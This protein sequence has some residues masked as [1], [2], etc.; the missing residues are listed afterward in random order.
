[1][2]Y[3]YVE[4]NR[5]LEFKRNYI[6]PIFVDGLPWKKRLL[7]EVIH[8]SDL[9]D[10]IEKILI[11]DKVNADNIEKKFNYLRTKSN[12]C[13]AMLDTNLSIDASFD[14]LSKAM[15]YDGILESLD[16][17]SYFTEKIIEDIKDKYGDDFWKVIQSVDRA[18]LSE[19]M[20]RIQNNEVIK[21]Y[22]EDDE[23]IKIYLVLKNWQD[24][25]HLFYSGKLENIRKKIEAEYLEKYKE[26]N[27]TNTSNPQILREL[28][29]LEL[30]G[31]AEIDYLAECYLAGMEKEIGQLFGGKALGLAKL[32]ANNVLIPDTVALSY[33]SD[34]YVLNF[35]SDKYA[36]RSSA[37]I[38]D[39][40]KYSFAGMFDTYLDIRKED[41]PEAIKKV[42]LSV[43][44]KRVKEYIRLNKLRYPRMSVVIQKF[45]EPELAGV[46][47]G[48]TITSGY[49]EYV[50]GNGEKLVSGRENPM[51]ENWFK[52]GELSYIK[53]KDNKYIGEELIRLQ[54]KLGTIAD[55]E[56]C[57]VDGKL[58][59]LQYRAV[60]SE[61]A[62]TEK[63]SG[64]DDGKIYGIAAS[65]GYVEA[66]ATYIRKIDE[67]N[68]EE[69]KDG[70]ILMAW[71][72][73]PEW[74]SVLEHCSGIV[75]AVG[76]FLCHSAIIA[77]ELGIP[78]VIGI[79]N[80]MKTIWNEKKLIVDGSNGF[81]KVNKTN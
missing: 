40:E 11:F 54:E 78:C 34:N 15:I 70:N 41:I 21:E 63:S 10:E 46:W 23:L 62:E 72:T 20:R 12:E 3:N 73:D 29:Q 56:W 49:L 1:M 16:E 43:N 17:H 81:V 39:G 14:I 75:T 48:K 18:N 64:E 36:V 69:W 31:S 25:L 60:T 28:M 59:L 74:L 33:Q 55:F 67:F 65:S 77:R 61:I 2:N 68:I 52:G 51:Q 9:L 80:K 22:S 47:M 71:F 24:R 50:K 37:D 66:E 27:L 76:G 13:F 32:R 5:Y 44:N 7:V 53:T 42:K 45:T 19:D 38:E 8:N 4:I 30:Q 58:Y 35:D 79:G 6:D 26:K 57:L